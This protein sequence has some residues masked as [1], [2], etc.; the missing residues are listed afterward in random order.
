MA[1]ENSDHDPDDKNH[2]SLITAMIAFPTTAAE[3]DIHHLSWCV[4]CF[5]HYQ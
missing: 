4:C 2:K 1:S 5:I 3:T